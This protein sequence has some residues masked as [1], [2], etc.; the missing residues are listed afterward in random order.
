MV[1]VIEVQ[2][3][4]R[5]SVTVVQV[6]QIYLQEEKVCYMLVCSWMLVIV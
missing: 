5:V 3:R 6:Q 4:L 1:Q 2:E